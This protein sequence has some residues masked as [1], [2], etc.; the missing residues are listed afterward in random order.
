MINHQL[1]LKNFQTWY[2]AVIESINP[3]E[4]KAN[5]FFIDYGNNDC[6]TRTEMVL[7]KKDIPV[8]DQVD[9]FVDEEGRS[10]YIL[11]HPINLFFLKP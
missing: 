8:G 1:Q 7:F 5:V 10:I 9:E 6:L 2:R 3:A 11:Y 4:G